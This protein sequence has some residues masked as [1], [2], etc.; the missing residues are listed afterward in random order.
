MSTFPDVSN[1]PNYVVNVNGLLT[2]SNGAT[3]PVT[4]S[5]GYTVQLVVEQNKLNYVPYAQITEAL[6]IL[7]AQEVL[8]P[9]GVLNLEASVDG[10]IESIVNPPITPSPQPLPW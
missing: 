6:A 1:Q 9:Q 4:A 7:W 3:P 8:T 2:G 10:Q 5:I